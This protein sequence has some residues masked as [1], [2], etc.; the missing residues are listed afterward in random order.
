[1]ERT[2]G[3]ARRTE[4]LTG[5]R[6]GIG[7]IA[8]ALLVVVTMIVV[9]GPT[10]AQASNPPLTP[11]TLVSGASANLNANHQDTATSLCVEPSGGVSAPTGVNPVTWPSHVAATGC[12]KAAPTNPYV[13]THPVWSAT[14]P[15]ALWDGTDPTQAGQDNYWT[16][17]GNDLYDYDV[18]FTVPACELY[19]ITSTAY[20][21]NAAGA[22]LDGSFIAGQAQTGVPANFSSHPLVFPGGVTAGPG[23]HVIDFI[24][25]DTSQYYTGLL[26]TVTLTPTSTCGQ[27]TVCKVAGTG[28]SVGTPVNFTVTIGS[29][30]I[31]E[32]VN[33]GAAPTGNC[34]VVGDYPIGTSAKVIE[35]I[36]VGENVSSISNAPPGGTTT[37]SSGTDVV[38]LSSPST[39]VTYTDTEP[40]ANLTL[41]KSASVTAYSSAGT[42]ITY[43]YVV[44]NTGT[45]TLNNVTVADPMVG[46]SPITCTPYANPIPSLA[47][48]QSVTCTATYTTTTQDLNTDTISNT[49]TATGYSPVGEA[50]ASS[51]VTIP[52]VQVPQLLLLKSSNPASFTAPGQLITYTFTVTNTGNVTLSNVLVADPMVGL[53][54]ISCTPF[55]NPIPSLAPGQTVTC[56]A[57]YTTTA[58]D[59]KLGNIA[60][61]AT[62]TGTAPN[63]S[64]V[65]SNGNLIIPGV[66]QAFTCE[67]P[68]PS[69]F[70]SQTNSSSTLLTTPTQLWDTT[71]SLGTYYRLGPLF[72]PSSYATYNA[73]GY[74]PSDDFL[75]ATRMGTTSQELI[76]LDSAGLPVWTRNITGFPGIT[77]GP[78][79]G[80]FDGAG[81]YWITKGD[82]SPKAYEINVA[83]N[84]PA[85]I[86]T[87]TFSSGGSKWMPADWALTGVINA[88]N[89]K[90]LWG[91]SGKLMY[92]ADL[93]T[94]VVDTFAAPPAVAA[95][96]STSV[97]FGAAWTFSN[98]NLGVSHNLTGDIFEIAIANPSSASPSF[99]VVGTSPGPPGMTEINDGAACIGKP[100]D[101]S[102]KKTGPATVTPGG[103][104]TWLLT[105]TNNGPG[106]SSGYV[107]NDPI[108]AGITG[109][110]TPTPGCT[111][112]SG[113]LQC[114]E[115][116]LAV[117]NSFSIILTGT[118]P[119]TDN[120]CVTNTGTVTANEIDTNLKNNTSSVQTCT[121]TGTVVT[122]TV[123]PLSYTTAGTALTYVITVTNTNKPKASGTVGNGVGT[124]SDVTV[125]DALTGN[126]AV[127]CNGTTSNLIG[128]IAPGRKD[129]CTASYV[130][131]ARDVT[132][133]EIINV[134]MASWYTW[135]GQ[136][137]T[138]SSNTVTSK[139]S[140]AVVT[141]SLPDGQVK[142][143]YNTSLTAS[144]GT[145]PYTW[146][147]AKGSLPKGLKLTPK[148]G[149]P[150][151]SRCG[152]ILHLHR[153]GGEC[154]GEG[155][156]LQHHG[157]CVLHRDRL[158]ARSRHSRTT[159]GSGE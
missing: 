27:L 156:H 51:S 136:L 17:S 150:R 79:V 103:T 93:T 139:A 152:R 131:T 13:V 88:T 53:S 130:T 123:T 147:L 86:R 115:G 56:T 18:D 11:I 32:T 61:S 87:L 118:A 159:S 70:L 24:I 145:A 142:V 66:N 64:E 36:P 45:F 126:G 7:V 76:K 104:I 59:M 148:G 1:M 144:G 22:Y 8:A 95:V 67:S 107:V 71:T 149:D 128:A 68:S 141:A 54:A 140:L 14:I 52:G 124:L 122:K 157:R 34:V 15:G 40:P 138:G 26:Y 99:S 41:V 29:A 84:P 48:S 50:T 158:E 46:L 112:A 39:V 120:V 114:V 62:A 5:V 80:A 91:V 43:T 33:A 117:G 19:T 116:V 135:T 89:T 6:K 74:D 127:H 73:L 94:G 133:G 31:P 108:P 151:H 111:I 4:S 113:N 30:T 96:G 129:I 146:T 28:V 47:P 90:Y 153:Q 132:K 134:A 82:G 106:N 44:T 42:T 37:L 119:A 92:R 110:S 12:R 78:T 83:S 137:E 69:D 100:T 143:K 9:S 16:G 23:S 81:N 65:N 25:D 77:G 154:E 60:N 58:A 98:G 72:A 38:T 101:L 155:F 109:A 21:D 20:A 125:N 2:T 105:V 102:I 97:T 55:A 85:V 10:V 75:Y 57:T 3:P 49:G 121:S 63:G 35:T